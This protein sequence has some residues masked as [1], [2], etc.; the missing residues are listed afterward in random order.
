MAPLQQKALVLPK[1][2]AEFEVRSSDVPRPKAGQL[3]VKLE[4]S[5]LNPVDYKIQELGLWI[6]EFPTILGCEAAG[7]VEEL[8]EGVNDFAKGDRVCVSPC[9]FE[10]G[11]WR[12]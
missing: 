5:A 7:T 1:V 12:C 2:K 4:A 10:V 8:G 3:L 6:T 9:V 11:L